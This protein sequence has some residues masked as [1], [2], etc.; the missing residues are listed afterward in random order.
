[1]S[2]SK[3]KGR[4]QPE[5]LLVPF[6]HVSGENQSRKPEH[7]DHVSHP[8]KETDKPY[9]DD[10]KNNKNKRQVEQGRI[11]SNDTPQGRPDRSSRVFLLM[12]EAKE[13]RQKSK[14]GN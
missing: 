8:R 2:R 5:S 9:D 3:F 12:G 13:M 1:V 11:R 4:V 6:V 10:A 7:T 14:V